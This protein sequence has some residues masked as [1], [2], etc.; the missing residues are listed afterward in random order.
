MPRATVPTRR[1]QGGH[2]PPRVSLTGRSGPPLSAARGAPEREIERDGRG[3]RGRNYGT[4]VPPCQA[5]LAKARYFIPAL[6]VLFLYFFRLWAR[7]LC[8]GSLVSLDE[9]FER[10]KLSFP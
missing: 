10:C 5:P 7:Y 3:P 9:T 4:S 8:V 6:E 2:V 1:L